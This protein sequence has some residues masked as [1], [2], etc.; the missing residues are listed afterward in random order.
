MGV[1]FTH[2]Q[3]LIL[4][5]I[6]PVFVFIHFFALRHKNS[7]ALGF[8]NFEAIAR[9]K[10]IT[11][12][13][14]NITILV[15]NILIALLMIFSVAG[16]TITKVIPTSTF[17]FVIAIDA[18]SSMDADDMPPSR[19]DV[20]KKTAI[21]FVEAVPA[22]TEI[23]VISFS[24]NSF[25]EQD[26]T[27]DKSLLR[28]AISNIETSSIGGT[29]LY[30]AIITST[31]ILKSAP[32]KSVI[33]LS[34][35]QINVGGIG[36]AIDYANEND[37]IVHTIAIGTKKGGKTSFGISK[38]DEKSLQSIAYSTEGKYFRAYN[39][40]ELSK[41]FKEILDLKIKKVSF[42]L[43]RH[44]LLAAIGLFLLEYFLVNTR[45]RIFP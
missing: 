14:K 21:E 37:V 41:I 40:E 31:N 19:I 2:P 32:A 12:Y 36:Q 3:Y 29:D 45:Y 28:R 17:S 27:Q 13:S 33:L 23:A 22:G 9:I 10:G 20:A 30:E 26:L 18:S 8:A 44:L 4:L 11:L 15:L 7:Y 25:I 42:N 1:S 24:G 43:S 5:A 38:L 39:E 34:D 16:F 35:G 6:L